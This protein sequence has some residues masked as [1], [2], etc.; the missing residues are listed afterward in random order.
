MFSN[1]RRLALIVAAPLLVAGAIA[2]AQT[3][4]TPGPDAAAPEATMS[5]ARFHGDHG[6]GP[7][8]GHRGGPGGGMFRGLF[9]EVDADGDGTVAQAEI[10]AFRAAQLT[11]ADTGGDGS[12]SIDEFA[13]VYFERTRPQMVDAFQTFDDD[14]DGAITSAELDARFGDVVS[15]LDR[16]GDGALS[17][18]DR[19]SRGDRR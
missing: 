18:G 4:P 8:G 17:P 10:D 11:A 14:G 15:H 13:V 2:V 16:D 7:D 6:R 1:P 9:E 19:G 5:P 3:A 12:V